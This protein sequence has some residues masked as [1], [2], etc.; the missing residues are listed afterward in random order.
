MFGPC[1]ESVI[2][3]ERA[4]RGG[5]GVRTSGAGQPGDDPGAAAGSADRQDSDQRQ[6]PVGQGL[7]PKLPAR[8]MHVPSPSE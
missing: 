2:F 3:G 8:L 6:A 1:V 7:R 5:A 4:S